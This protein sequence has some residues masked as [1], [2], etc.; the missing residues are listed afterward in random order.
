MGKCTTIMKKKYDA[1]IEEWFHGVNYEVIHVWFWEGVGFYI[2]RTPIKDSTGS[3]MHCI[4]VFE[5]DDT[6]HLSEDKLW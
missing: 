6:V 4:R 3:W 5:V 1:K 2:I